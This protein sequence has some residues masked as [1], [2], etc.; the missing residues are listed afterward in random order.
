MLLNKHGS[1]YI[2][3]G[4][5]TKIIDGIQRERHIFSPNNELTAVD[6]LGVGRV[7]VKAM[8]YWA[9]ALG[10][11]VEEKTQQGIANIL[12]PLAELI[13][14][15]DVYCQKVGTLWLLHRILATNKDDATAWYWTFNI[16]AGKTFTKD[17]FV[18]AFNLYVEREGGGYV[19]RAIEKEFDCFKN[20]Y[21]SDK[22]FSVEKILEED[23]I[24]FFAPLKLLEYYSGGVFA[25]RKIRAN[26]IPAEILLYCIIADNEEFLKNNTQISLERLQ[27]EENQIG[28][29]AN[30]TYAVLLELL[31]K[32]E[33]KKYI[34]LYNNFGTRYIEIVQF[35]KDLILANYY[36]NN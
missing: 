12:T 36:E 30:L 2:R 7:M 9:Q 8:R 1:F 31:Q 17:E 4:W 35:D 16:Y 18:E 27:E 28:K 6:E 15:Y 34:E 32:L 22:D 24:P 13:V 25:K 19:R 10:L 3:N 33:N 23:T 20:T 29:Y 26:D 14:K 5:P 11:S 21:V